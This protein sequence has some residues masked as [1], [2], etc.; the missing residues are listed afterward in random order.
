MLA[1]NSGA[2]KSTLSKILT[3]RGNKIL[4]DDRMFV[5]QNNES[6]YI[7]GN[8]CHGT[9]PNTSPGKLPLHSIFFLEQSK[10]NNIEPITDK[11]ITLQKIIQALVKPVLIKNDWRNTLSTINDIVSM[12][13]CYTLQFDLSGNIC[14]II[15][16]TVKIN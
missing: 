6:L 15:E 9:V 12:T 11:S 7:H 2:G 16:D 3:K 10:K 13:S 1:G 14:K 4:C 5:T 8:W